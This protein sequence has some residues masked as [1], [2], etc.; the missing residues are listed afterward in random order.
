M[1][2]PSTCTCGK[3]P[4]ITV[5]KAAPRCASAGRSAASAWRATRPRKSSNSRH[6]GNVL[7]R[8]WGACVVL[9]DVP[10]VVRVRVCAPMEVRERA[11]MERSGL[12]DRAPRGGRSSATTPPTSTS[13]KVAYGVD[14]EDPWLYDL[15][16]NTERMFDRNVCEARL[17][18][19]R[20]PGVPARP[21]P[22]AP[23]SRTRPWKRMSASSFA[24]ASSSEQASAAS[25]PRPM[26]A[27]SC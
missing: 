11:V 14:R 26:A 25:K 4:S 3:V 20:Q 8:G 18:S 23:S 19:R 13:C 22:R 24:N 21:R 5:S 15:V 17:R 1:I 6:R 7:I 9:R 27:G 10:H 16:L 2:S 12:N